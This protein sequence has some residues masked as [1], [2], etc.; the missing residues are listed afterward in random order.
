LRFLSPN[1]SSPSPRVVI[2]APL[3]KLRRW[4]LDSS[5]ATAASFRSLGACCT[6]PFFLISL[7][8]TSSLRLFS[9]A[10]TRLQNH[11]RIKAFSRNP[12][13]TSPLQ[14]PPSTVR[15]CQ[16]HSTRCCALKLCSTSHWLQLESFGGLNPIT[17]VACLL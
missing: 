16:P 5:R 17:N 6:S 10:Q 2:V 9:S 13:T 8:L 12:S 3:A 11:S 7:S 4:L 1:Y 15:L 14:W